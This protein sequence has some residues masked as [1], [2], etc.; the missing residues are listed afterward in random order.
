[1]KVKWQIIKKYQLQVNLYFIVIFFIF[2]LSL[3]NDL[4]TSLKIDKNLTIKQ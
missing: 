2:F 4:R 1:M 3:Q